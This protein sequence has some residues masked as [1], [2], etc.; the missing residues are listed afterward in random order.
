MRVRVSIGLEAESL[1]TLSSE[2]AIEAIINK[3]DL[4]GA[5]STTLSAVRVGSST[6]AGR[7]LAPLFIAPDSDL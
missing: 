6:L 5:I 2:V 7:E 3:L 1:A 4:S